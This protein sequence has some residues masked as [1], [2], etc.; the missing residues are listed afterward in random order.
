MILR[1]P[2]PDDMGGKSSTILHGQLNARKAPT[3]PETPDL[4]NSPK[5]D[6]EGPSGTDHWN[7]F[8]F[9]FFF[10]FPTPPMRKDKSESVLSPNL[11]PGCRVIR[12]GSSQKW[13]TLLAVHGH[14]NSE[15]RSTEPRQDQAQGPRCE[16]PASGA[17]DQTQLGSVNLTARSR[18]PSKTSAGGPGGRCEGPC[19]PP[20]AY[21]PERSP[22]HV[23]SSPSR[24]SKSP[25]GRLRDGASQC[26]LRLGTY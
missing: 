17:E 7:P 4:A 21:R 24:L 1:L 11:N 3:G 26:R 19:C 18:L 14:P 12:K 5:H 15:S 9:F 2:G 6:F 25:D 20:Y 8:S 10:F 13:T 16:P 22:G 23:C